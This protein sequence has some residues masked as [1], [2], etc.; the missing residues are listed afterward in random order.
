MYMETNL[1]SI[2]N[3]INK[4]FGRLNNKRVF[5]NTCA[6]EVRDAITTYINILYKEDLTEEV[7]IQELFQISSFLEKGEYPYSIFWQD[8]KDV[9]GYEFHVLD[10]GSQRTINDVFDY[11][12]NDIEYVSKRGIVEKNELF[13]SKIVI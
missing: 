4:I 7:A 11:F 8:I 2:Q 5:L 9:T 1:K 6:E 3:N 12:L 13:T 10:M